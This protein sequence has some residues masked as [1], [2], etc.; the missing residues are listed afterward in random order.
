MHPYFSLPATSIVFALVR[1]VP[2]V[3]LALTLFWLAGCA[4]QPRSIAPASPQTA[5]R[6]AGAPGAALSPTQRRLTDEA[7]LLQPLS[8]SD[9]TRHFLDAASA[10][11]QVATRTAYVNEITREYFS[12]AAKD[13]LPDSAKARLGQV[14]LDESRYYYTKYGTPLAYLRALEFAVDDSFRDVAGKRILDFGYGSIGH[15][16]LLASLGAQITGV[17]PDSYLAALYSDARDQGPVALAPIAGASRRGAGYL[18][19]VSGFWPKDAKTVEQVGKGYD[20]ILSKNTLKRGYVKPERKVD[21]K[22]Q[23]ISLGVSD[24]VFL[25]AVFNTLA[26]GGKLVIYNLYPKPA[27]PK[28]KYKPMADGRSPFSREQYEK[29]GLKVIAFDTE[30]HAFARKMGR[31]LKWDQNAQGETVDDLET[32]LYA[33]VTVVLRPR[34]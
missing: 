31:L 20:L 2:F 9:L 5:A 25:T 29:A 13:A 19:L 33:L 24:Q 34:Q 12:P 15:L 11:P 27:G 32:N 14:Q 18:S 4:T 3:T 17:D 10:L 23:L 6:T 7:A 8:Q 1:S 21:D 22:R 16:R 30:D 28:E 26:P